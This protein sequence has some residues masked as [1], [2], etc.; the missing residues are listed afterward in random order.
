MCHSL[1]GWTP[2]EALHR[3]HHLR[4]SSHVELRTLAD[5]IYT[6]PPPATTKPSNT[7]VVVDAT[8][9][10][11]LTKCLAGL[12]LNKG[13]QSSLTT[14]TSGLW[15]AFRGMHPQDA[16]H[17]VKQESHG[18]VCGNG[19]TTMHAKHQNT[20]PAPE[21]EHVRVD[22]AHHSHLQ[23]PPRI[24]LATQPPHWVPDDTPYTDR[25][26]Q[27]P[28]PI[29]QVAT[30]LVHPANTEL[31]RPLVDSVSNPLYNG[32]LRRDSLPAHLQYPWLEL[33]LEQL[34][35]LTRH[36]RWYAHRPIPITADY[37]KGICGQTEDESC[38][39]FKTCPLLVEARN[40]HRLEPSPH[41]RTQRR[42][43]DTVPEDPK[44]H[45]CNGLCPSL[46]NPQPQADLGLSRDRAR[47]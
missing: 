2:G 41:Y 22:T 6:K 37:S 33:A 27:Y 13:L 32:A 24:P 7:W 12:R 40:P 28:T 26:R 5:I 31:L 36:Y 30:I 18:Y 44:A 35:L 39:H 20:N 23:H 19:R 9:D 46:G 29:E 14:Q 1:C 8:V 10:I 17:I 25:N 42:I 3:S 43:T 47:S 16:L 15:M 21:F 38:D 34:P 45:Y 4:A 11:H